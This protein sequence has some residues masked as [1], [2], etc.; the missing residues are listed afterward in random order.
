MKNI[1]DK[2][3]R[4]DEIQANKVELGTHEVELG[5]IDELNQKTKEAQT[6]YDNSYNAGI[7]IKKAQE[8]L[9]NALNIKSNELK[10]YILVA[11]ELQAL[12]AKQETIYKELGLS[13]RED[14]TY[15]NAWKMLDNYSAKTA[16]SY[17][18]TVKDLLSQ[19][20]YI[21]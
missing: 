14:K 4:A 15:G 12:M 2:I 11:K 1:L 5:L 16:E 18:N 19:K 21:Q 3:N 20:K 10:K 8:L 9:F 7:D 17:L 6:I 13:I